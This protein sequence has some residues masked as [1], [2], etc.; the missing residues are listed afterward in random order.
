MIQV[1]IQIMDRDPVHTICKRE[2]QEGKSHS[3][4]DIST[5]R[6]QRATFYNGSRIKKCLGQKH[7]D[8][9]PTV[10]EFP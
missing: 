2:S 9:R 5:N 8:L 4:C 10:K 6:P 7:L 3:E 1:G